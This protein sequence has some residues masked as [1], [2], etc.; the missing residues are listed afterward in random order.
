MLP[1]R[2]IARIIGVVAAVSVATSCSSAS[3]VLPAHSQPAATEGPS[4]PKARGPVVVVAVFDQLGS[5][6]LL[7]HLPLLDASGAVRL[8]VEHGV[9]FER[10]TYPFAS[11]LTAP[12]HVA[13]HTG[14]TPNLSGIGTNEQWSREARGAVPSVHDPR[15]K[16]FGRDGVTIGPGRLRVETVAQALKRQTGG[17][18]KVVSLSLKDRSA[19]LSVG[20]NPDLALWYDPA[21]PGFTSSTFAFPELP[22]WF[23][24]YSKE[25]PLSQVLEAWETPNA[26]RYARHLGPDVKPGE[27][28]VDNFGVAFPHDPKLTSKPYGFARLTPA[29]SEYLLELTAEASVQHALGADAVPDLLAVS[30]SG[31]DYVGHLFGPN[32]WEYVDHLIRA[33]RALG[34]LVRG[35]ERVANVSLV[36]TSDHG[37][38]PLPEEAAPGSA[39]RLSPE[40]IQLGL[41]K[42]LESRF[43]KR[44]ERVSGDEPEKKYVQVVAD[45]FVYFEDLTRADR[46]FPEIVQASIAYLKRDIGV[47]EVF[48]IPEA[49][50]HVNSSDDLRRAVALGLTEDLDADLIV[51][52]KP[53]YFFSH[54][55]PDT[56]GTHHGSPH[57]YDRQVP[58]L[59]HGESVAVAR[60]HAP[61]DQMRLAATIAHLLKVQPP[62]SAA[63]PSLLPLDATHP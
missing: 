57:E 60:I 28:N 55:M 42:E 49:R 23:S 34:K 31:T 32:S 36:I 21:L 47:L 51:I 5:E 11:T 50:T 56:Y 15:Y 45:P 62:T 54:G 58:I 13:I 9:F 1:Q 41:E 2:F 12:G 29:L 46:R 37:V 7:R 8:A 38:A 26:E 48:T 30:V 16:V 10:G 39:G 43:G 63:L 19:V 24:R 40:R 14:A 25:H 27:G 20:P 33:D 59:I 17:A 22:E 18:A 52:T 53:G 61:V 35:L 3:Q 6:T 44:P 4:V